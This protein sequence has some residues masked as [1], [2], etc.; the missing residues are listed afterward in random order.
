MSSSSSAIA[1]QRHGNSSGGA[2]SESEMLKEIVDSMGIKEHDPQVLAALSEY[3]RTFAMDVLCDSKDYAVHANRSSGE[4][5]TAADVHLALKL[6]DSFVAGRRES[7]AHASEMR[8]RINE[9]PLP[10]IP[11]T[12]RFNWPND[13]NLLTQEHTHLPAAAAAAA[14][15]AVA[16]NTGGPRDGGPGQAVASMDGGGGSVWRRED[17]MRGGTPQITI[18]NSIKK[19]RVDF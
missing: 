3:A 12:F 13:D 8:G 18:N 16:L 11:E 1:S 6:C 19:A 10:P 7:A 5:L 14:T 9:I 4:E 17:H 2:R 15:E